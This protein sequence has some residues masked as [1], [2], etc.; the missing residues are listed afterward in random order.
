MRANHCFFPHL[1]KAGIVRI[2]HLFTEDKEI[3]PFKVWVDKKVGITWNNYFQW[4]ITIKSIQK[5]EE[6]TNTLGND[7]ILWWK[8]KQ[9]EISKLR[10]KIAYELFLKE[11]AERP[12]AMKGIIDLF[13]IDENNDREIKKIYTIAIHS[14]VD[15]RKKELQFK[16]LNKILAV[17]SYLK[18]VRLVEDDA[19]KYCKTEPE[20][21][22]HLFFD[23][24]R[25]K[26]FRDKI[27]K[28]VGKPN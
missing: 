13:K 10:H 17:G 25:A 7:I 1:Y 16:I 27:S 2:K 22:R 26:I 9:L 28:V 15:K 6:T 18:K 11:K 3:I 20:T 19:C 12:T 21:I 5:R 4:N 8:G 23:C 24:P 14:E